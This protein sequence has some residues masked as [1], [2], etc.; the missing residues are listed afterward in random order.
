MKLNYLGRYIFGR[1]CSFLVE[2]PLPASQ[3]RCCRRPHGGF[4][5]A[6]KGRRVCAS[7]LGRGGADPAPRTLPRRLPRAL[8]PG[9]H[10]CQ[11]AG[12]AGLREWRGQPSGDVR[13][14]K[15]KD[16]AA[17]SPGSGVRPLSRLWP[18]FTACLL[19]PRT[20][21]SVFRHRDK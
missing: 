16:E 1:I 4:T 21:Y 7:P 3:P 5:Q 15:Q 20:V 17:G 9:G 6:W 13:G 2:K 19:T 18:P 11:V 12:L 8:W 14:L 10:G